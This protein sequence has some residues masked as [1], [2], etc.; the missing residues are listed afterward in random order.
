MTIFHKKGQN[1]L[2][3]INNFDIFISFIFFN[4]VTLRFENKDKITNSDKLNPNILRLFLR[5]YPQLA[6]E[7]KYNLE[8]EDEDY[9]V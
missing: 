1:V 6:K 3:R 2:D 8:S 5:H 9:E 4:L 7:E